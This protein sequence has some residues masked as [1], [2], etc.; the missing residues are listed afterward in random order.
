MSRAEPASR[1]GRLLD[2]RLPR[3]GGRQD[4]TDTVVDRVAALD[5]FLQAVADH[6]PDQRLVAARTVVERAGERLRLS[7]DHTVVALAGATGSGKSSIF[8]ALAGFD[9]SP[10]GVRRPTTGTTH[11]CVWG[12]GSAAELLDWLCVPPARR[13]VRESPLDGDDQ[14]SLRGL[15]LL[16]L[17]DFDSVEASHQLEV[18]RLLSLVDLVVWVL[19]PQKYADRVVHRRYLAEFTHHRDITVVALN[20]ADLLGPADTA[21]C[22]ADLR[23]LLTADGL[24]GVPVIATSALSRSGLSPLR[25]GLERAVAARLAAL[26]RLAGDVDAVVA[27]LAPMVAA[28][29]PEDAVDRQLVRALTDALAVAAGVPAVTAATRSAYL[30]RSARAMGWPVSRWLRRLRPD[31]LRRLHLPEL[32]AGGRS[33]VPV[34]RADTAPD[35]P[36]TAAGAGGTAAA[37]L[38]VPTPATSV[39]AAGH[40]QRAGVALAV[41]T[42]GEQAGAGLPVPWPAATTAAARSRLADLPD[43]LDVAVATTDLGMTRR[44]FWWRVVGLVQWLCTLAALVGLVW[45]AV[46]YALFAL[47]LPELPGPIVG[48]VPLATVLLLGGLLA[49]FLVSLLTRPLARIGARRAAARAD[50]RLRRG[51]TGVAEHLVLE[52]VGA[53]LRDYREARTALT[54]AR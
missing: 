39:P 22:V 2:L 29:P 18:D 52:P 16:D 45:L 20:Q 28:A 41:R 31:P 54:Q 46:R 21:R 6:L 13:F 17:P 12:A 38:A 27:D 30:H 8:N 7:R 19:D 37:D 15:V 24:D 26:R 53:V 35:S 9:L 25:A 48:R 1:A 32:P 4:R 50:T 44:P 42:V 36:A 14:A 11:A 5:E 47:G 23:R 51:V 49:G 40:A 34:T 10:V 43:A 3:L 33:P